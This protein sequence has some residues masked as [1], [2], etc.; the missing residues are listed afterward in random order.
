MD[1]IRLEEPGRFARVTVPEPSD[2]GPGEAL[3]GVHRVAICGTDFSGYLGKMPFFSYPRIPGHELAVEVLALG[4]GVTGLSVGQRCAVEPYLNCGECGACAADRPNCCEQ[5][6]VLGVHVDGGLRS[7]FVLPAAKLHPADGLTDDQVALVETLAIGCHAV[8]RAAVASG[9]SVLVV[10]AGPIGLSVM[11]FARIAGASVSALDVNEARLTFC[12]DRLGV[13]PA[14]EGTR[15][16]AVFDATGNARS[17]SASV[18]RVAHAGR[19]VYVGI[20]TDEVSF[21]HR[22]L[23]APEMDLLASRNALPAEFARVIAAIESGALDTRP[24]ITHRTTFDEL[25]GDF[26]LFSRPETGV[27]KAVVELG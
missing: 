15:F 11:E 18:D 16:A 27:V 9:E 8:G 1:A 25:I 17:M 13:Q 2:P 5:L 24:W 6:T 22:A 19:L 7:R 10:G 23:H 14:V 20:T 21:P 26:E 4:A 3:V 12:R